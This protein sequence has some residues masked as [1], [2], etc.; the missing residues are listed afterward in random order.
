MSGSHTHQD[1]VV[2]TFDSQ[3]VPDSIDTQISGLKTSKNTNEITLG[4]V[5]RHKRFGIGEVQRVLR[6]QRGSTVT[7]KF[8]GGTKHLVLEYANLE[9]VS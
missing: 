5:V 4:S 9:V 2:D 7:V 3:L 1:A 6:R 8:P